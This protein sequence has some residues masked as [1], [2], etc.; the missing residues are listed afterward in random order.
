M[1]E[2]KEWFRTWFASPY[3][4]KLYKHRNEKEA[5]DFI[6]MLVNYLNISNTDLILDAAFT[7]K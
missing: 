3:Y 6:S 1:S 2:T 4:F 7:K 5:S